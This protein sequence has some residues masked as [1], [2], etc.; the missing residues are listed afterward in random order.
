MDF[1]SMMETFAEAWVAANVQT[2]LTEAAEQALHHS[3]G[4]SSIPVH[5]VVERISSPGTNGP[6]TSPALGAGTGDASGG[7]TGAPTT[8][9]PLGTTSSA[10]V[11][12]S[13]SSICSSSVVEQDSYAIMASDVL[14]GDLV[15]TALLKLGYTAAETVGAKGMSVP[16]ITMINQ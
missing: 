11:E 5:C 1:Q 10:N 4:R 15:R 6:T 14:F 13:Q 3:V 7:S 2:P 16:I 8:P 9:S 12:S